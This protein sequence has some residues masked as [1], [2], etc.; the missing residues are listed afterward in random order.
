MIKKLILC[1]AIA[2][3]FLISI[4]LFEIVSSKKQQNTSLVVAEKL[5][6][7]TQKEYKRYTPNIG[8]EIGLLEIPRIESILPIIEG[9]NENELDKGVGHLASSAL[10]REKEQIILSGHRD[11]V[12]RRLGELEKGDRLIVHL[13]Y[14]SFSYEIR[15]TKIVDALDTTIIKS[16][17]P[18]E[19]LVL[20]T[21]YPFSYIGNAPDRYIIYA[22]PA[23]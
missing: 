17:Y 11:T 8:K 12:F 23:T 10:P 22:Y 21:C 3:G 1:M 18:Q 15:E 16:T 20:S 19:E 4:S 13:P 7:S 5:V 14:G 6:Q 2:G 9:T